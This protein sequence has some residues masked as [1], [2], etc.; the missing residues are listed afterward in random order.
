MNQSGDPHMYDDESAQPGAVP[1]LELVVLYRGERPQG[2]DRA[3]RALAVVDRTG[4]WTAT[5]TDACLC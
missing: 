4:R 5:R 3:G 2:E 1:D